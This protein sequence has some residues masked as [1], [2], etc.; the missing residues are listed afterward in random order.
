M[1]PGVV[2]RGLAVAFAIGA[3]VLVKL[4][5][6]VAPPPK[7]PRD[8]ALQFFAP[9]P[10][11]VRVLSL[12]RGV[13]QHGEFACYASRNPDTG[14]FLLLGSGGELVAARAALLE[15][16]LVSRWGTKSVEVERS[17]ET[18]PGMR[19]PALFFA[20]VLGP[21]GRLN[22]CTASFSLSA[23]SGEPIPAPGR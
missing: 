17:F 5:S 23:L 20:P 10:V 9:R 6:G 4:L 14:E 8:K 15:M 7:P 2:I 12:P 22:D 16:R 13:E 3:L 11:P 21:P 18:H 19:I 1:K